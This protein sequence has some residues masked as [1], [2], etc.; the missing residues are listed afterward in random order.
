MPDTRPRLD[1]SVP[2]KLLHD[3]VLVR[4]GGEDGER[5]S[6]GGIVIPACIFNSRS[7]TIR[8]LVLSLIPSTSLSMPFFWVRKTAKI[9]RRSRSSFRVSLPPISSSC[10]SGAFSRRAFRRLWTFP[11]LSCKPPFSFG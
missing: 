7:I 1:G 9:W 4:E 10:L 5:R 2:I 11:S 3:R 8:S 6:S